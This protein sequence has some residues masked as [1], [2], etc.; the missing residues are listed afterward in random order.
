MKK[1]LSLT[2]AALMLFGALIVFA[3]CSGGTYKFSDIDID[4]KAEGLPA[5]MDAG[6]LL[7]DNYKDTM[8]EQMKDATL[9]IDGTKVTLSGGKEE[10]QTFECTKD[11]D[12][13]VIPGDKAN[14]LLGDSALGGSFSAYVIEKSGAELHAETSLDMMGVKISMSIVIYFK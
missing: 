6:S 14:S 11:G 12:K 13:L 4:L 5:G 1:A 7:G 3:S 2:L 8:K 9:T 10:D